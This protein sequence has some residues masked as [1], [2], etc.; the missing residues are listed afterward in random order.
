[1]AVIH[2]SKLWQGCNLTTST[3]QIS[4]L[5]RRTATVPE[6]AAKISD[7]HFTIPQRVEGWVDLG[8][9]V[10]MYNGYTKNLQLPTVGFEPWSSHTTVR[11][12]TIRPLQPAQL[13]FQ[14]CNVGKQLYRNR[15][16]RHLPAAKWQKNVNW[17]S[18]LDMLPAGHLLHP[19][20]H[21]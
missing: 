16:R 11:H 18:Q 7:T 13:K 19:H 3:A 6:S 15:R 5:Q 20:R 8:T 14:D 1:M 9:A 2:S 4:R 12:V 21:L 10:R 17:M